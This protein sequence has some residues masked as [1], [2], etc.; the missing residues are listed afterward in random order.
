MSKI[1]KIHK[2]KDYTPTHTWC[3]YE[4]SNI[5]TATQWGRVTCKWCLLYKPEENNL[6][7]QEL[8]DV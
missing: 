6:D 2:I 5:L 1:R 7:N 3:G 4:V 8:K